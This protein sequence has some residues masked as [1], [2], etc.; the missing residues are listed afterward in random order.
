MNKKKKMQ[1]D[2][3]DLLVRIMKQEAVNFAPKK[4]I[5]DKVDKNCRD[6]IAIM[7]EIYQIR[8]LLETIWQ[9]PLFAGY[10]SRK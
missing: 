7:E 2:I 10:R 6:M 5:K 4:E 8:P 3:D 1:K 9:N